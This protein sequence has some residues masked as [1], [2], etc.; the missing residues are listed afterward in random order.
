[1][2]VHRQNVTSEGDR[3]GEVPVF[4]VKMCL[5]LALGH[6]QRITCIRKAAA[7]NIRQELN[8]QIKKS[9]HNGEMN[10]GASPSLQREMESR[11]GAAS[12]TAPGRRDDAGGRA[13]LHHPPRRLKRSAATDAEKWS[14]WGEKVEPEG[15]SG[16]SGDEGP[17]RP[18]SSSRRDRRNGQGERRR[19]GEVEDRQ[20]RRRAAEARGRRI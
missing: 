13:R 12:A 19:E 15:G 1:M 5:L 8:K 6:T 4:I 10:E 2:K 14:G 3:E 20:R 11:T 17:S 18:S 9:R 7:P 16:G